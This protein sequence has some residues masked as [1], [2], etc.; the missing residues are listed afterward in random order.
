MRRF[1][2]RLWNVVRP[3]RRESELARELEA[4]LAVLQEEYE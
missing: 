3:G 1:F 4:H 2:H